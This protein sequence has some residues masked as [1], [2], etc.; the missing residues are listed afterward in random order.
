MFRA[1]E[2][3]VCSTAALWVRKCLVGHVYRLYSGQSP[4]VVE[5]VPQDIPRAPHSSRNH[6]LQAA[7]VPGSMT[8]GWQCAWVHQKVQLSG[9]IRYSSCW[10]RWEEGRAVQERIEPPALRSLSLAPWHIIQRS[11]ECHDWPRG[12]L[13][14]LIG[15]RREEEEE[16]HVRTFRR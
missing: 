12:Y 1:S 7:G 15:R 13:P 9:S 6:A 14:S 11:C 8:R 3:F 16:G 4:S 10:Y 5:W 2:D